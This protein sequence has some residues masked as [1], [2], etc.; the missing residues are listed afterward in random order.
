MA[1]GCVKDDWLAGRK[2]RALLLYYLTLATIFGN[3]ME[4]E[5]QATPSFDAEAPGANRLDAAYLTVELLGSKPG[6]LRRDILEKK[7]ESLVSVCSRMCGRRL[8]FVLDLS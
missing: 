5:P 3:G 7:L 2:F 6:Q 4:E 8:L 1:V